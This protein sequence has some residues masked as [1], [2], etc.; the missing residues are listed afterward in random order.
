MTRVLFIAYYFP[1]KGGSGVQRSLKFVQFLPGEGLLP[2]VVTA[3]DKPGQSEDRWAPKDKHLA[4]LI[5]AEV[6]VHRVATSIPIE[7][8][9]NRRLERWLA[10]GSDHEKWWIESVVELG[11]HVGDDAG[12]IFATMSPY[13]SGEAARQLSQKLGIPWVADLRDPWALDDIQIYP[14]RLHRW[15]ELQRM[16]KVLSTAAVIIMNT[17]AAS[18]ALK[19][20]VPSLRDKPIVTITNGY[21]EEDFARVE[22]RR[23]DGKFRIV[24]S[25]GMFTDSG[26]QLQRRKF[27]RLLGGVEPGVDILT[28]SPKILLEA[29][30]NWCARRPEIEGDIE[31]IFAGNATDKDRDVAAL[32]PVSELVRFSGYLTH[33]ESLSLTRTSDLLFLPMHNLPL[34]TRCRSIP[35]KTFEYMA[36]GRPILAAVPDGDAR[37]FLGQC[38]TGLLCRPDDVEGMIKIL[39]HVYSG[40][41]VGTPVVSAN[42]EYVKQFERRTLTRT[43]SAILKS[44]NGI[45]VSQGEMSDHL[46]LRV[47]NSA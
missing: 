1:P 7:N 13:E 15:I 32:S 39:D 44:V 17:P 38:G 27:Y 40:W 12:L 3:P 42:M 46:P 24:H 5:P 11:L 25:G 21:D 14:S 35:G 9:L 28:R 26:L 20:K 10:L 41:K 4:G 47:P 43:L 37:D 19:Q 18:A 30:G 6:S 22:P 34:G 8:A 33:A 29:V 2:V 45:A 31:I 16:E 36:T 23:T